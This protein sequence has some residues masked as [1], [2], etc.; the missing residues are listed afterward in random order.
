MIWAIAHASQHP[1]PQPWVTSKGHCNQIERE[2]ERLSIDFI[3]DDEFICEEVVHVYSISSMPFPLLPNILDIEVNEGA[4]G[5]HWPP[6]PAPLGAGCPK[7]EPTSS[8]MLRPLVPQT[9]TRAQA[10]SRFGMSVPGD[11]EPVLRPARPAGRQALLSIGRSRGTSG[12][13]PA[14]LLALRPAVASILSLGSSV[15]ELCETAS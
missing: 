14:G 11:R 8:R 12:T 1:A 4:V 9:Q 5:K 3:C 6:A 13:G 2:R 7:R 10:V 15:V